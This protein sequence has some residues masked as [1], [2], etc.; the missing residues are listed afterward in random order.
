M[1]TP[2]TEAIGA[3]LLAKLLGYPCHGD[4]EASLLIYEWE[5]A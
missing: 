4:M 2:M 5:T 3:E 1:V